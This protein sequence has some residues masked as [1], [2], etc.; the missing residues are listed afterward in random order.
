M[1][2]HIGDQ[3]SPRASKYA[4]IRSTP[5]SL[6]MQTPH[7]PAPSGKNL[8]FTIR[9]S[10]WAQEPVVL[11]FI[12]RNC[13]KRLGLEMNMNGVMVTRSYLANDSDRS[14]QMDLERLLGKAGTFYVSRL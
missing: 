9:A 5:V 11:T 7:G 6:G 4:V 12:L 8:S 1:S 2:G 14:V 10:V 3:P 13:Q